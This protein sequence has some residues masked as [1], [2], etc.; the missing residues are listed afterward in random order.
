[1][2]FT[3]RKPT[4]SEANHCLMIHS[5]V[6]MS[7]VMVAPVLSLMVILGCKT[8]EPHLPY[9][10]SDERSSVENLEED[11]SSSDVTIA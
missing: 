1:M 5:A 10:L 3:R 2:G 6:S 8:M 7:R 11:H 9:M 4:P